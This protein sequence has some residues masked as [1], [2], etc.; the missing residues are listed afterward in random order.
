MAKARTAPGDEV[1]ALSDAALTLGIA[2]QSAMRM[3]LTGSLKGCRVKSRWYVTRAS[4]AEAR[5][6]LKRRKAAQVRGLNA[7]LADPLA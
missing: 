6:L 2:H 7:P 1:V 3:V 5:R 4:L